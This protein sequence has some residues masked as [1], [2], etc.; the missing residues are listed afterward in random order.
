[1][2]DTVLEHRLSAL[3][4]VALDLLAVSVLVQRVITLAIQRPLSSREF[5]LCLMGVV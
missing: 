2:V 3:Q 4:R 1:M 5:C